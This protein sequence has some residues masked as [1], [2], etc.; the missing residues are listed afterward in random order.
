MSEVVAN[1]TPFLYLAQFVLG[2]GIGIMLSYFSRVYER[3]Y[4]RTWSFSAY[5]FCTHAIT[6]AYLTSTYSTEPLVRTAGGLVSSIFNNIHIALMFIGI[7]EAIW[8]RAVKKTP[9]RALIAIAIGVGAIIAAAFAIDPKDFAYEIGSV[10]LITGTSFVTGG[11]LLLIASSLRG[12]GVKIVG[13]CFVAYG[14]IHLYDVNAVAMSLTGEAFLLPQTG[15]VKLVLIALIGLGLVIW[16]LEDEQGELRKANR[17]LD[18][19]IYS[20]SH[21]LRAPVASVL[22]LINVARIDTKDERSLEFLNLIEGRVHKLDTVITDILNLSRVKKTELRYENV[23]F[24][25]LMA[26]SMADV[27]F[28]EGSR[29]IEI[30]YFESPTNRF[31]G[32]YGLTKM[33]LGNLLSNAVKYHSPGK[34]DPYIEVHFEKAA[35]Q[36]SFVVADN[37]EGIDDE[38]HKKIFDMFYRA[39]EKSQGTGL[40]LYIVKET[41]ARIGGSVEVKSRKGTGTTFKVTLEQPA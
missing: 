26:D 11:V 25:A 12:I 32:D 41:L 4:L 19:I 24:N 40:G 2:L 37:G 7:A 23:D 10:A 33:V 27:K 8:Q 18:S 34:P 13:G 39:S 1:Q 22:G 38:H 36:V 21:D 30:R 9:R 15:I 20:T 29:K 14:V 31:M 28:L 3:I 16:L 5:T 35:G 6:F 17:E